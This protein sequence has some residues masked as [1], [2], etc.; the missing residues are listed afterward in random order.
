MEKEKQSNIEYVQ[1]T[2]GI[3]Y[4]QEERSTSRIQDKGTIRATK[5]IKDHNRSLGR[6][7]RIQ[8]QHINSTSS[9]Q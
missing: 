4:R 3:A 1:N 7:H 6:N 5:I 2:Y 8:K 9:I